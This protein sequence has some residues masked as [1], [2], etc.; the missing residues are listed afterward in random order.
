MT[1][2]RPQLLLEQKLNEELNPHV[3]ARLKICVLVSKTSDCQESAFTP[4]DNDH[5]VFILRSFLFLKVL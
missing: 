1:Q 3:E 5:P 4:E 2:R